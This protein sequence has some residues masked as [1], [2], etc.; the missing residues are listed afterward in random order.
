MPATQTLNTSSKV[1]PPP[2]SQWLQFAIEAME[3]VDKAQTEH[4]IQRA[5]SLE[6]LLKVGFEGQRIKADYMLMGGLLND[7]HTKLAQK[8]DVLILYKGK[9]N[10]EKPNETELEKAI[11]GVRAFTYTYLTNLFPEALIDDS[12]P[13][14]L[15]MS[16]PSWS[17]SFCLHFGFWHTNRSVASGINSFMGAVK[18]FNKSKTSFT[19]MAPI[20]AMFQM[21]TKNSNTNENAKQMIRILKS[22]KANSSKNIQLTGHEISSLV[23]SMDEYALKKQHGQLLFLLLECSL[24]LKRLEDA[25]FLQRTI[26][27]PD[28]L[29]L[30]NSNNERYFATGINNLKTELDTLIKHLVLEIDLY[31]NVH[32]LSRPQQ[33]A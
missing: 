11:P 24:F 13:L 15:E 2:Q 16:N 19:D 32:N 28:L 5:D 12:Q 30:I 22:L 14:A 9:K 21:N 27:S 3:P 10:E 26:K 18:V 20:Q 1:V 31:T 4:L 17:C 6:E 25:V 8:I 23:Y 33:I 7:T 29:P